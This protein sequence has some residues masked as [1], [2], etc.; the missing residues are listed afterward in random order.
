MTIKSA[1]LKCPR[2]CL[3]RLKIATGTHRRMLGTA[4][5]NRY[6]ERR[7]TSQNNCRGEREQNIFLVVPEYLPIFDLSHVCCQTLRYSFLAQKRDDLALRCDS[8]VWKTPRRRFRP[9]AN[10]ARLLPR[11]ALAVK[12]VRLWKILPVFPL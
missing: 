9:V 5:E 3:S 2:L 8:Q 1:P 10:T 12:P 4:L 11:V 7:P 6:L